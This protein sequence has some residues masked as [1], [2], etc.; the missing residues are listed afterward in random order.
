[1]EPSTIFLI[2]E[3]IGTAIE[4][5]NRIERANGG[6]TP[7]ERAARVM[8]RKNLVAFAKQI[9]DDYEHGDDLLPMPTAGV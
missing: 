1:M 7:E 6:L 4:T 2:I 5:L 8:F 9:P 3:G